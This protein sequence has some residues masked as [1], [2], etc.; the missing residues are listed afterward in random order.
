MKDFVAVL[1]GEEPVQ[2]DGWS[3]TT[4]RK[5]HAGNAVGQGLPAN[6]TIH[7]EAPFKS[8]GSCGHHRM[9]QHGL[10]ESFNRLK[11]QPVEALLQKL[12]CKLLQMLSVMHNS[13]VHDALLCCL[14]STVHEQAN[15]GRNNGDLPCSLRQC[16]STC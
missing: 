4:G 9:Q 10:S 7:K 15:D 12:P 14:Y 8:A 5:G 11:L 6:S 13:Y 1:H 3:T 16:N 2:E